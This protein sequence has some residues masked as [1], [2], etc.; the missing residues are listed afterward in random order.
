MEEPMSPGV[1]EAIEESI[2]VRIRLTSRLRHS[3]RLRW[4]RSRARAL[5]TTWRPRRPILRC[6]TCAH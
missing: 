1:E 6:P 2:E 4:C 5:S 3:M